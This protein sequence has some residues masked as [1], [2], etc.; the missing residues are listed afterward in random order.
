MHLLANPAIWTLLFGIGLVV[1]EFKKKRCLALIFT[2]LTILA[3][4]WS[5]HEQDQLDQRVAR[6]NESLLEKAQQNE[7]LSLR[8]VAMAEEN[9]ELNTRLVDKT[10]EISKVNAKLAEQAHHI[11]DAV[12]GGDSFCYFSI[13]AS[14]DQLPFVMLV[15]EGDHP[16]FQVQARIVDLDKFS[17]RKSQNYSTL[18]DAFS[19]KDLVGKMLRF[20]ELD[21]GRSVTLGSVLRV[22][23]E[24]A[25]FNIFFSARSGTFT[26]SLR[27]R[28]VGR[29][30]VY[31]T[32]VTRRN[33]ANART[34]IFEK[35]DERYPRNSEGEVDW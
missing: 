10:E 19:D 27:L 21:P 24:T 26:Q 22:T 9:A 33:S 29:A 14:G 20:E 28:R 31:A 18:S 1:A 30:W 15:H 4:F 32:K 11:A 35:I 2:V 8:L 25:R 17:Q 12:T 16:L 34:T 6:L 7:Q 3:A 13:A 23:G 5:G